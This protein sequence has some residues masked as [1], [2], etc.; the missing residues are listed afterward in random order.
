MV[1]VFVLAAAAPARAMIW[2]D[3]AFEDMVRSAELIAVVEVTEGGAFTCTAKAIEV[4]KGEEPRAPIAVAGYNNPWWPPEAVEKESLA[5][6]ERLL[7][8]LRQRESRKDLGEGGPGKVWAAPTPSTGDYRIKEGKL[9]G[10]W[11]HVS[12]P[13]GVAGVDAKLVVSLVR[14]LVLHQQGQEP[15][16]AR[17]QIARCLTVPIVNR[18]TDGEDEA[19]LE[20]KETLG[21]LLCA[22]GAYGD[23]AME[24]A[25]LAAAR[26]KSSWVR[27]CAARA[28]RSCRG[29]DEALSALGEL[30]R[31]NHSFVQAEAAKTMIAGSFPRERAVRLLVAA[32][33]GD[34]RGSGPRS[35]ADPLRNV[36]ASGREMIIR[37]LTRFEGWNESHGALVALIQDEEDEGLNEGVFDALRT[38][39]LKFPS[40]AARA[41]FLKLY[42]RCPEHSLRLFHRYLL[43]ERSSESLR[44]VA[45]K[46][47]NVDLPWLDRADALRDFAMAVEP[48]DRRVADLVVGLLKKHWGGENT[49]D[50]IAACIPVASERIE[51]L[52]LDYPTKGM[53][54]NE[55]HNLD[56]ARRAVALKR[57]PPADPKKHVDVWL[58]LIVEEAPLGFATAY[59]LRELV[60]ATPEALSAY[61]IESLL[62]KCVGP[63]T[64]LH[65]E[66]VKSLEAKKGEGG[67]PRPKQQWLFL[68]VPEGEERRIESPKEGVR[69]TTL[70]TQVKLGTY[71]DYLALKRG[72]RLHAEEQ[73]GEFVYYAVRS[74]LEVPIKGAS[75]EQPGRASMNVV[76][77]FKALIPNEQR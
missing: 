73:R 65:E 29:S 49:D 76:K 4:L 74:V 11:P 46:L 55:L 54:E 41:R 33:P 9:H 3:P 61:A 59:L 51:K 14:G 71:D 15:A 40:V 12:Y 2:V 52:L 63:F 77:R 16:E 37:A 45:D 18:A 30:L 60:R 28:L 5:K 75:P 62:T 53:G 43:A 32:L 64:E 27:R 69:T 13:H 10:R 42:A 26:S 7:M 48:G 56:I 68:G 17:Q 1:G 31:F 47:V 6:G 22:Q 36:T 8:F 58:Q 24:P 21:W 50:I 39:F 38:H 70:V 19:N 57:A 67:T 23:A 25:V 34:P 72:G 66:A 35:I 44:A 20:L